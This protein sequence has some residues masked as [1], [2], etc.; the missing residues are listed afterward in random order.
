MCFMFFSRFV[1]LVCCERPCEQLC[2][3][4]LRFVRPPLRPRSAVIQVLCERLAVPKLRCSG[5]LRATS[6]TITAIV[7]CFA[8]VPVGPCL[9]LFSLCTRAHF[10]CFHPKIAVP[11]TIL[12]LGPVTSRCLRRPCWVLRAACSTKTAMNHIRSQKMFFFQFLF[13]WFLRA[14]SSTKTAICRPWLRAKS[15]AVWGVPV[16]PCL[17]KLYTFYTRSLLFFFI[18]K[19]DL[20]VVVARAPP[21]KVG[22]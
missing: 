8:S 13:P 2:I 22:A 4:K 15:V 3:P 19:S 17:D 7:R 6:S 20:L 12:I 11:C 21:L 14:G 1:F 10:F 18:E 9:V 16:G 5:A